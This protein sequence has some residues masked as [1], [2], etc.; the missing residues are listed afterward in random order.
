MPCALKSVAGV[1]DCIYLLPCEWL[2]P[3]GTTVTANGDIDAI[4][5]DT[6]ASGGVTGFYKFDLKH[7]ANGYTGELDGT[8]P[9]FFVTQTVTVVIPKM[10]T[11][12]R[13]A[14]QEIIDCNCGLIGV[15]VD[16]NCKQWALGLD[17]S[18]AEW[19]CRGL[20]AASGW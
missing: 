5:I 7:D 10:D 4:A 15:V 1:N 17:Y 19:N 18:C 13:K 20:R 12:T 9:N 6:V 2:D 8:A 3:A 14:L 11:A 16:N